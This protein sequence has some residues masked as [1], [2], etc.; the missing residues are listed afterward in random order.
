MSGRGSRVGAARLLC[1]VAATALVPGITTAQTAPA[2][3]SRAPPPPT[4]D[5]AELDPNAP[6]APLPDLGVAWPEL[7]ASDTTPAQPQGAAPVTKG[8]KA[9]E[10][11]VADGTGDVRYTVLVEGLA[12]IGNA[13]QL[14]HDFRQQSALEA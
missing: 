12:P 10:E 2:P 11:A 5:A 13:D 4:P 14:L 9:K 7:K 3:P 8:K 1:A 6:L